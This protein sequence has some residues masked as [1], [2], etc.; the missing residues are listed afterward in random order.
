[1]MEKKLKD[2]GIP[3]IGQ[4]PEHWS[5]VTLKRICRLFNGDSISDSN[6][7]SYNDF[8]DSFPYISTKD[9]DGET[10]AIDY[11]NGMWIKKSDLSFK[12][13]PAN[14]SIMCIEGG[15]AGRKVGF[16]R[17]EIC[18]VNKL[19]CFDII[20]RYNFISK[21]CFYYLQSYAFKAQFDL[22]LSGLIGGV[23]LSLIRN[24]TIPVPPLAE[25]EQIVAWLDVKCGE[26]DELIDVEQQ[27]ISDLEAYRQAVIT[28][29]VTRGLNP[30]RTTK[31]SGY[32]WIGKIPS[33]WN[34]KR[35]RFLGTTQ[36]GISKDGSYFGEGFPF[37]NYGDVYNNVF[38][39]ENPVNLCKS[40]S[41]D[42]QTYSIEYGDVLFTRTS[43]TIEEIGFSA[44]CRC[45]IPKAVFSGFLIRF[46]PTTNEIIPEYAGY[47]FRS[48]IH[49]IFFV[50]E[51]NIVTRASLGQ[52]LLRNL[53]ILLPHISEQREIAHYLDLKCGEID[54][55]IKVKQEK[56]ETLK[57]YRQS[58]IFEAVTG[59][60][61]ID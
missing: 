40:D 16:T 35:L 2:S 61:T 28:E 30:D 18:F 47:Y 9:V 19:A 6:K 46:R 14:T 60:T 7:D 20:D 23:S 54:E 59:K 33:E 25:Q 45:S 38:L 5:I 3:W 36:N 49:R 22:N 52:N 57:Q 21:F 42:Q 34:I 24:F 53:P 17:Q 58:L 32:D 12:R 4:I 26:I 29:A 44:A 41:I 39:P 37:V 11:F 10:H 48:N 43:E 8:R 50:K 15:S 13:V 1:M 56:I 27:M 31:D 51:M 55:L